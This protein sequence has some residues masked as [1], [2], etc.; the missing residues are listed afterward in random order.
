MQS[1]SG[2]NF[3]IGGR[4]PASAGAGC[5]A[6]LELIAIWQPIIPVFRQRLKTLLFITFHNN[7]SVTLLRLRGLR[8]SSAIL[9]TLNV[10]ID[11]DI[12]ID[13]HNYVSRHGQQFT[14]VHTMPH[15]D[16]RTR[17]RK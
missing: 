3:S 2:A 17:E 4:P 13:H 8:N 6:P 12:D 5:I 1:P 10:L 16:Q 9:A 14:S 7:S 15:V 11:T